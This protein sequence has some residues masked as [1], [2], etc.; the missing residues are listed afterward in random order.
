MQL[1]LLRQCNIRVDLNINVM[2]DLIC[3]LLA[4]YQNSKTS[5][6]NQLFRS[7]GVIL[8]VFDPAFQAPGKLVDGRGKLLGNHLAEMSLTELLLATQ[9]PRKNLRW[10]LGPGFS[11]F[12][13][14]FFG[15][16]E[17]IDS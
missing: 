1:Q 11:V 2:A 12:H 4:P 6:A 15:S 17:F 5:R 10:V 14:G 7:T 8:D 13:E 9:D 3:I 16:P